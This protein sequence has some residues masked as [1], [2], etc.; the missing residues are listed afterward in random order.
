M[1]KGGINPHNWGE[2]WVHSPVFIPSSHLVMWPFLRFYCH[3]SSP[4]ANAWSPKYP[5]WYCDWKHGLWNW[6]KIYS[7]SHDEHP[8]DI[9][10]VLYL[11]ETWFP[12]LLHGDDERTYFIVVLGDFNEVAH[13]NHLVMLSRCNH[14]FP[15]FCLPPYKF[16]TL[17]SAAGT[18]VQLLHEFADEC[19]CLTLLDSWLSILNPWLRF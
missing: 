3:H 18:M 12:R 13:V 10:W 7:D 15:Y 9:G 11:S 19:I 6:A 16:S 17:P 14:S 2:I 4:T 8:P 5:G 1:K